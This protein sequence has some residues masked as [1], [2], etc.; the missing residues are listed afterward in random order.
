MTRLAPQLLQILVMTMHTKPTSAH[1]HHTPL[2]D[3]WQRRAL[4]GTGE[5]LEGADVTTGLVALSGL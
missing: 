4:E 3:I 2:L 1:F 5:Q